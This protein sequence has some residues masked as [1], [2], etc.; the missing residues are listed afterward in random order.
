MKAACAIASAWGV[1][2]VSGVPS[3]SAASTSTPSTRPIT[4]RWAPTAALLQ[5]G[6]VSRPAL[7]VL[8]VGANPHEPLRQAPEADLPVT[9]PAGAVLGLQRREHGLTGI[10][11]ADL[12]LAAVDEILSSIAR[13]NHCVQR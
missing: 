13:N 8:H 5:P 7:V 9:A 11:P 6:S 3:S 12:R 10:A 4:A 2:T 1:N